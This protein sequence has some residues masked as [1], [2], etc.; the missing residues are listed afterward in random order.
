MSVA[1]NSALV[2][3]F[4]ALWAV[5]YDGWADSVPGK[6]LRRIE[7]AVRHGVEGSALWRFVWRDGRIP[8]GWPESLTCRVVTFIINIPCMIV[9]WLYKIWKNVWDG[10][11]AFRIA[12]ALGGATFVFLG[13]SMLLML[14]VDHDNWNNAYTLLC[15]YGVMMLF[16]AGCMARPKHRLDL[17]KLGP[18]YTL[19][20]AFVCYGFLCSLGTDFSSGLVSGITGSLSWRFFVFHAIAFLITVL[21][22]SSVQKVEQ[23]QLM[24]VVA[25]CGLTV[26]ALYG[27]YQGYIG[28]EVVPSQQDLILNAGMP[29]RVYSFF[30]NPNNFGEILIMLMPFLL[31][32]FLNAKGWRGRVLALVS[33]A[34]CVVAIGLTYFRTGWIAMVLVMAVFLVL[35][36]WR[37]LPLFIVVGLLALPFLP[38][39]IMNR[40]LTI[41]NMK[42]SSLRYRFAIYGNT[43][44]LLEDY[45]LR[46]VGLGTDVMRQVFKVYP[47][48]YDGN[49]PIHTHNNYLQMWGELGFFGALTYVAMVLH[50]LKTGVK[51]FYSCTDRRIKNIL[52]AAVGAF[53]GISVISVAEYTWF[54]PR[55]MFVYFF[56]FGVIAACVKLA[57]AKQRAGA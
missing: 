1:Q 41:G 50:Q 15:M 42:D 5:L 26:S 21:T 47:T 39:S 45:G 56:L 17:D 31:A 34:V 24:L 14:V 23:L 12:S 6:I 52:A 10:S 55:N 54:Y 28:V 22:V 35:L 20:M 38:D 13:L 3:F 57:R 53:F 30:D 27:C 18:Y 44:Y 40:I 49:Y 16:L 7:I 25:L 36:N 19:F 9:Q 8:G 11:I 48:M 4:A 32:L 29:G 46:G 2:R 51:T 37:F 33:L 43:T